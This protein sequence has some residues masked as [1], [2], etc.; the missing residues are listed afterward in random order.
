MDVQRD[1]VWLVRQAMQRLRPGGVLFFSNNYRRFKLDEAQL[2]DFVIRDITN[3]TLDP[4]F[5]RNSRIH[6]CFEIRHPI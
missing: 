5:K 6:C 4:D 3:A 1:H 2:S